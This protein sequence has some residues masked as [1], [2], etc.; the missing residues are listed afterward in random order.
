MI[1]DIRNFVDVAVKSVDSTLE[2][3]QKD[4]FGNN[5]VTKTQAVNNYNLIFGTLDHEKDAN[6]F[7]QIV[8]CSLDI[9]AKAVRDVISSYDSLY[10]K[11]IDISHCLVEPSA[12]DSASFTDLEFLSIEPIEE[13]TS[14]NALKMRLSFN[15]RKDFAFN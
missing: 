10:T 14:D 3:Y 6:G 5:D 9:Y 7:S 4:L 1:A 15:V 11:A 12:I 2:P 8:P 13:E